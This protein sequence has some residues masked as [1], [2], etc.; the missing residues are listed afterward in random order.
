M[1]NLTAQQI[2]VF[3]VIKDSLKNNGYP[4][5]RVE[6][7]KIL[8]FKSVNAAESHIK[9]LVKK[10][11]IEKVPG[12]SRGIKLIE[13]ASGIPLI[14]A[15][16]AGTPILAYENVEKNIPFNPLTKN[17]DFFLRV[18]GDSMVDAGILNDDLVGIRKSADAQNGEI[19]VARIDDEVT[20]K[21]F[22]KDNKGIRLIAENEN[23]D[24][25]LVDENSNFAVEGKAIGILRENI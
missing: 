10:G 20:L 14:G 2:K 4:P 15:V 8:G 1:L 18:S 11:V 9:A 12:S 16:A 24:D 3:D 25:I 5:T 6:I 23:Y 21:R 13:E 7:A 17:V 22:K 19:I